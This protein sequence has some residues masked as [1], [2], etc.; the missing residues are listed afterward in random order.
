VIPVQTATPENL[1]LIGFMGS[2]KS[3]VGRL[4]AKELGFQF[5]DTDQIIVDRSGRQ[6]SDIFA[7]EGEPAF[8]I[9]E[10]EVLR[11]LLHLRR[12]VISTGEAPF[13]RNTTWRC[14]ARWVSSYASR[15]QKTFFRT[16]FTKHETPT[17]AIGKSEGNALQAHSRTQRPLQ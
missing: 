14:F 9:L 10:T 6:I 2:G 7:S 11:S 4:L 5:L 12:C 1:V 13:F 15:R 3:S 16:R 8:R 17:A